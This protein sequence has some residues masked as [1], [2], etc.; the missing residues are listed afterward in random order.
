MGMEMEMVK[1]M[2]MVTG[3]GVEMGTA[4]EKVIVNGMGMWIEMVKVME[5]A[6]VYY[7]RRNALQ[8]QNL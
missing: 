6:H 8:Q 3:I 2:G 7:Q 5:L 4:M 1:V